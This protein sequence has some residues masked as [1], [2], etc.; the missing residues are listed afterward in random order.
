VVALGRGFRK[1]KELNEV[2]KKASVSEILRKLATKIGLFCGQTLNGG[3]MEYLIIRLSKSSQNKVSV[4]INGKKN[5]YVNET[6]TL[7]EGFVKVSADVKGA[8]PK[9]I[10][11]T[12]TTATKPAEVTVQCA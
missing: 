1:I 11:L 4:L 10:E 3:H 5:G 7:E 6:L 12:G 8:K 2:G 9:T